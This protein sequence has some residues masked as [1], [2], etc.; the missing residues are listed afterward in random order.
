MYFTEQTLYSLISGTTSDYHFNELQIYGK[1]QLAM[2][3][4]P[5][6]SAA[7]IFFDNMIG[8]RSGAIHIGKNQV[9][10]LQRPEIDLPFSVH[11]YDQGFLGMAPDTNIHGVDIFLNG[12]YIP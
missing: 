10:D 2:L 4:D 8:D 5:V 3:T 12:K 7:S 11:V 1:A 9:M 6:N